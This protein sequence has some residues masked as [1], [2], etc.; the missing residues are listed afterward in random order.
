M[1]GTLLTLWVLFLP[2]YF[3][4]LAGA[5]SIEGLRR[6]RAVAGALA[7]VSAAVVGVIAELGL[8]FTLNVVF[9]EVDQSRE[10]GLRLVRPVWS[11]LD[12]WAVALVAVGAVLVFG[13]RWSIL[14]VIC[15]CAAC[16][17]VLA[18]TGLHVA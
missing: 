17:L 16:G 8:W 7:A 9:G 5:P 4:V 18:L 11:T 12:G 13:L 15:V 1:L 6:N 14:R 3:L 10:H 2:S